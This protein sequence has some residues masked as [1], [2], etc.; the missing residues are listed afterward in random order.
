MYSLRPHYVTNDFSGTEL[1]DSQRMYRMKSI[2]GSG[3]AS[4]QMDSS[5]M[6]ILERQ[7][8][9][10]SNIEEQIK[11]VDQLLVQGNDDKMP[12][13]SAKGSAGTS[14]ASNVQR[15]KISW[16]ADI[17]YPHDIVIYAHPD[18]LP[19][20]PWAL[21]KTIGDAVLIRTHCHSSYQG[22]LPTDVLNDNENANRSK[23]VKLIFTIIFK[24]VK[25]CEMMVD[26]ISQIHITGEANL[27]RYV[28]R[29]FPLFKSLSVFQET[30]C[31]QY[32]D[33]ICTSL[34]SGKSKDKQNALKSINVLLGKQNLII[35]EMVT[36]A[37]FALHAAL[38]K[39][40][41]SLPSNV[42]KWQKHV[43]EAF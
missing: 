4:T 28:T 19:A 22:R 12:K 33:L 8:L 9:L 2:Y 16:P 37:D 36:A 5:K 27:L 30:L 23:G 14:A 41:L 13:C 21:Q 20:T 35:C 43:A 1:C 3:S 40:E 26:P 29:M 39:C 10:I 32:T 11:R 15:M 7:E 18:R 42:Q 38:E 6:P 25:D 17:A 31:D 34:I 24:C